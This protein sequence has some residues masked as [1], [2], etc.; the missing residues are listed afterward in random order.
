MNRSIVKVNLIPFLKIEKEL[1]KE[2]IVIL[3]KSLI[4]NLETSGLKIKD[5]HEII[6][7][8]NAL[9]T[10]IF[11]NAVFEI[12]TTPIN[13]MLIVTINNNG[14]LVF[15]TF[16]ENVQGES[17]DEIAKSEFIT[18]DEFNALFLNIVENLR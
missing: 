15:G 7:K 4:I 14:L 11:H 9:N 13:K 18:V 6:P 2:R 8:M 3:V 10:T 17:W 16:V 1:F 12:E 5:K